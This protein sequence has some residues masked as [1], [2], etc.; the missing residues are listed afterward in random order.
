MG[1]QLMG[2]LLMCIFLLLGVLH[3]YWAFGGKWALEKSLPTNSEG[4]RV[5]NPGP[6]ACSIVGIGL[7]FFAS[8]YAVKIGW[9]GVYPEWLMAYSGW[10]IP[11]IFL[12]RTIG[13]FKYV[14]IFKKVKTTLFAKTDSELIIPLCIVLV[15]VG[16]SL[17]WLSKMI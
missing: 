12:L 2:G 4:R 13:D 17:Q 14:G 6:V 11:T 1:M 9:L 10:F 8:V 16:Y 7:L 3:F 15:V 5:L